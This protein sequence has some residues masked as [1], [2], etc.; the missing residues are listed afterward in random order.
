MKHTLL[1]A[2]ATSLALVGCSDTGP[3]MGD[4][5]KTG[6]AIGAAVGLISGITTDDDSNGKIKRAIVGA[7]VGGLIGNELDKQEAE[8]REELGGSGALITNTGSELI[9]T[10][11]EAITFDTDSTAVRASLRNSLAQLAANLNR[12]PDT[13]VD[14]VGH[15]DNVG[16]ADYN[17]NLSARRADAVTSILT[18]NGVS[19]SRI[20]SYGRGES[21]PI[22]SNDTA[23]GRAQNRRVEII[24]TPST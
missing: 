14:V 5:A 4:K 8:L 6:A 9:V 10:L 24:I 1:L 16:S 17:Q 2:G 3:Q 19:F 22:A 11:P 18:A 12:Y 13:G 20:R 15:T 7:T 23:T 21:T